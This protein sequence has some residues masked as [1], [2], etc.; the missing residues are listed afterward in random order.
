MLSDSW[1]GQNIWRSLP[2]QL[3]SSVSQSQKAGF[4]LNGDTGDEGVYN[5][6]ICAEFFRMYSP[7]WSQCKQG[8][9]ADYFY[10][11]NTQATNGLFLNENSGFFHNYDQNVSSSYF[12]KETLG[13]FYNFVYNVT[14]MHL[15]HSL[16]CLSKSIQKCNHNVSSHILNEFFESL[17]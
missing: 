12:L 13:F 5:Q 3:P 7:L 15:N 4:A 2:G 14:T 8:I 16:R 11:E 17:W 9:H 1:R 6:W 10:K